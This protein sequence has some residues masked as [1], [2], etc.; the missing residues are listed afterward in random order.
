MFWLVRAR[1]DIYSTRGR[2]LY[3]FSWTLPS[4][5]LLLFSLILK[6]RVP[7]RA[8]SK[9][10][11][12]WQLLFSVAWVHTFHCFTCHIALTCQFYQILYYHYRPLLVLQLHTLVYFSN[13]AEANTRAYMC[14]PWIESCLCVRLC[15]KNLLPCS[16]LPEIWQS[17]AWS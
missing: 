16:S 15:N 10:F 17:S 9:Y 4:V 13:V 8:T 2:G 11:Y 1:T 3:I 6:G 14:C 7:K 5:Q 12:I